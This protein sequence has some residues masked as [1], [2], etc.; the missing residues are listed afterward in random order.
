MTENIEPQQLENKS[1]HL[2]D[3]THK[4]SMRDSVMAGIDAGKIKMK[5]HWH[6]VAKGVLLIIGIVL[7]ILMLLYISSFII[8]VLHQTGVW[9]AP[10]FGLRGIQEFLRDLPWLLVVIAILFMVILQFLIKRYSFSYGRPLLFSALGIIVLVIVGGFIVSLTP[11]HRGL[12]LRAQDDRLPFA[13]GFYRHHG[14]PPNPGD[15]TPGEIIELIE[16]GYKINTP[17]SEILTIVVTPQTRFPLGMKFEVGDKIVVVGNRI[18][19]TIEAFGI[20]EIDDI[21]LPPHNKDFN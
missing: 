21:V 19:D 17:R 1:E 9:F 5:P 12:M 3:K 20:R 13:G 16:E 15:V 7:A 10:G 14:T 6:F 8:F 4:R 2:Q 11:V 18:N